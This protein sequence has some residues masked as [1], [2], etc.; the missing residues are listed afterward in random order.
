MPP[1]S[2]AHPLVLGSASP[3]RRDL[4]TLAGVAHVV[5]AVPVDETPRAG[6][7]A[8]DYVARVAKVKLEA[9]WDGLPEQLAR[10]GHCVLCAD[11]SVV[12]DD[13]VLGKPQTGEEGASMLRALS[14]REHEVMTAFVVGSIADRVLLHL[15][16]VTTRVVFRAV[17]EREL[18]AY[19]A[20]GEGRDKAGGY[21]IQGRAGAMVRRIEGSPTNVI[22]LPTCE[23]VSALE[24]LRLL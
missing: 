19:V 6:E 15:E 14:D 11:T 1:I 9:V 17:R 3:R 12:L 13:K 4:L 16:V 20:S 7:P 21:A 24:G 18:R 2:E 5:F 22:G 10:I 8:A 23:V